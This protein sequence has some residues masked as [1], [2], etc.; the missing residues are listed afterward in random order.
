MIPKE[1][2][3]KAS[4]EQSACARHGVVES[5]RG[6][7]DNDNRSCGTNDKARVSDGTQRPTLTDYQ[8]HD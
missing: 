1:I 5:Y 7:N 2:A 3:S 6:E 8:Y 4:K